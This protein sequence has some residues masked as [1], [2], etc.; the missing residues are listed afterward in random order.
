MRND[1]CNFC[2]KVSKDGVVKDG[3]F[4][5]NLLH[6]ESY[7]KCLVRE[8]FESEFDYLEGWVLDSI[9]REGDMHAIQEHRYFLLL[10][11]EGGVIQPFGYDYPYDLTK[12][13]KYWSGNH[14]EGEADI[15]GVYDKEAE[16]KRLKYKV[17]MTVNIEGSLEEDRQKEYRDA[18]NESIRKTLDHHIETL[19]GTSG[20]S[21]ETIDKLKTVNNTRK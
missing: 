3:K 14:G 4:F 1:Q 9:A 19:R 13:I 10:E 18:Q 7:V 5:C 17:E 11:T 20:L 16:P 12:A 21:D 8:K 15:Y 6:Y 2:G